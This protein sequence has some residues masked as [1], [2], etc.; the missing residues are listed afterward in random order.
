MD[1]RTQP[2][3]NDVAAFSLGKMP[4]MIE[5]YNGQH[6]V[7]LSANLHNISLG[8]AVKQLNQTIASVGD[9]PKGVSVKLRGEAPPLQQTLLGLRS[10]LL[11]A[12]L[13]IFLLLAANFQSI[14][15]SLA[16]VLTLPAVI[17]G[18]L[19]MLLFTGTTLNVQSFMGA[20]MAIGI[21]V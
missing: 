13:V 9:P 1:G 17:C 6:I 14:R 11:L 5:R 3:L 8:D 10:G 19:L 4:G 16:I 7:S 21:A 15:L 12:I 20:I 2:R 18:I